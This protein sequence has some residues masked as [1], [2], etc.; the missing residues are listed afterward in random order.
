MFRIDR[1]TWTRDRLIYL[2]G[3]SGGVLLLVVA[4]FFWWH[5]TSINPERVYWGAITN[6]LSTR[7]VTLQSVQSGAGT[8]TNQK[9]QLD[10]SGEPKARSLTT[11]SRSNAKVVTE[12]LSTPKG[13]YTRYLTIQTAKKDQDGKPVSAKNVLNVW[14]NTTD[15]TAAADKGVPQL[16]GQGLLGLSLPFGNLAAAQRSDLLQ[17]IRD[18]NTY[19][20]TYSKVKKQH[21]NGRLQYVYE[22]KLQPILYIRFMKT[23]AKQMG[24]HA[25]DDIEPNNY[26]NLP[27]VT[28]NWTIDAR[29]RQLVG[30][31][32]GN[33]HVETYDGYG[34]TVDATSPAHPISA[35]ELQ[36]RLSVLQ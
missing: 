35:T 19:S 11:L 26:T 24:L 21:K 10:F 30:V 14:A 36:K 12:N 29:A 1:I 23:Y 16:F 8:T 5:T 3:I 13:D 22:V 17:S 7:G 32:Y 20:T 28:V 15:K 18:N 31:D 25:L 2:G 9:M 4:F 27:P 33:G 34:L 6:N